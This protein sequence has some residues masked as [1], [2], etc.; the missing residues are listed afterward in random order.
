MPHYFEQVLAAFPFSRLTQAPSLMRVYAVEYAEPVVFEQM[1]PAVPEAPALAE[2]VRQFLNPDCCYELE[3]AW[4]LWQRKDDWSLAPSRVLIQC[5]GAEFVSDSGEHIRIFCGIDSLFLPD[6]ALAGSARFAES[7]V[8]SLLK[9]SHD[10][11]AALP[12]EKRLLW[13]E[14]GENFA[15]LLERRLLQ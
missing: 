11:D 9:L 12:V 14:S 1:F 10:L 15:A 5:R 7:N 8:R 6:P 3:A 4:D 13:T 2:V